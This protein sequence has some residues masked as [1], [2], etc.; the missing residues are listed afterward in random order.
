[1]PLLDASAASLPD[2][3]L[4][5]AATILGMLAHAFVRLE[6][7]EP[8]TLK[9]KKHSDILPPSLEL[10]WVEVC[11]R[12]GRE[13]A[14]L[15]FVEG[16]AHNFSSTSLKP[17]G[18][19]LD[20]LRL[21]VE[22]DGTIEEH[23]FVGVMIE[24]FAKGTP[25]MHLISQAQRAVLSGD[26]E[27]LKQAIEAVVPHI[28]ETQKSLAKITANRSNKLHIDPIIWTLTIANLGIPWIDGAVGAAGTAHPF[29]HMLDEF[30]GRTNY[31]SG[32]GGEAL[33][34]RSNY[35][36]H[37]R[38]FLEAVTEVSVED[39]VTSSGDGELKAA[40]SNLK[41][42]YNGDNGLLG[43]HRRKVF[44]FLA[45]SFRIG[46]S[47]TINGLGR[48]RKTEPWQEA[49]EELEKARV[50]RIPNDAAESMAESKPISENFFMSEVIRHNTEEDE[51]WFAANGSVYNP[52]SYMHNHPGGDTVVKLC[53]GQDVTTALK[54]VGHLTKPSIRS[55][56]DAFR[57]GT[58]AKPDLSTPEIEEL[59]IAAV[60]L[61]QKAAEMENVSRTNLRLLEGKFTYL[62]KP[63]TLTAQ[64][65]NNL[66]DAKI[67]LQDE[68]VPR[69]AMLLEAVLDGVAKL[70]ATYDI[71]A[72]RADINLLTTP[73]AAAVVSAERNEAVAERFFSSYAVAMS[74][75]ETDLAR[76]AHLKDMIALVMQS[77]EQPDST[78]SEHAKIVGIVQKLGQAAGQL[79][80][81]S[82]E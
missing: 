6:G 39:Y 42:T 36:L 43:F 18:V 10:P 11:K 17:S 63:E 44:G 58:V 2:A 64:K 57:I 69:L 13:V 56:L 31:K 75:I 12:L 15:T 7:G 48:N 52:T 9:Y 74:T 80:V 23:T 60:D 37:W 65:T 29:F 54:A 8:L 53:C 30:T 70:D 19:A 24:I 25:V 3:D 41:S 34:V 73:R 66:R 26:N 71:S 72:M 78:Q 59:Y 40:W 50:E 47:T 35:P 21:L 49:D 20:N 33:I 27:S 32:I 14:S 28:K 51:Y 16:V 68:Y 45:V 77:L 38:Q 46:R 67:R 1:M 4:H 79:V 61:G 55:R 82:K 76:L 5:R 22:P 81:L 62:D